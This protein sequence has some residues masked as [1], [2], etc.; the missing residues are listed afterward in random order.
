[1]SSADLVTTSSNG[2][3]D[4]QISQL[5]QCK[6][7]SEPEVMISVLF[8]IFAFV[9]FVYRLFADLRLIFFLKLSW[10]LH[11]QLDSC[12]KICSIFGTGLMDCM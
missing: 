6:P 5:M 1:M 4:D 12:F 9:A 2:N 7:L 3:L 10:R 8:F 11:E